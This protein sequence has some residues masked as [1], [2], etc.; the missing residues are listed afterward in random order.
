MDAVRCP[1]VIA[2]HHLEPQQQNKLQDARRWQMHHP[3]APP[4]SAC[5]NTFNAA[6]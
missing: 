1:F 3:S 2:Q 6:F 4:A 5:E